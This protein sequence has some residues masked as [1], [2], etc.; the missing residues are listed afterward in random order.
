MN[1]AEMLSY[2]NAL[3]QRMG[4]LIHS[5][6]RCKAFKAA[7][8]AFLNR[9]NQSFL[10]R[11]F[12]IA[13]A[14]SGIAFTSHPSMAQDSSEKLPDHL[15]SFFSSLDARSIPASRSLT[16]ISWWGDSAV[17]GDGYTGQLRK[18]L[19]ERFGDGGAGIV[20]PDP[21]FKGY[22]H[23]QVR[24][25][26]NNWSTESA[27]HRNL[28]H[29]RYGLAGIA[30]QSYGGASSTFLARNDGYDRVTVFFRGAPKRG[31]LQVYAD[32]EGLPRTEHLTHRDTVDDTTWTYTLSKPSTWIRVRAA[33]KG[34][35]EL[36]A[37]ALERSTGGVVLDTMGQVGLR[38]R[39]LLRIDEAH[40]ANQVAL[41]SPNLVAVHFGGNERVDARLTKEKHQGEIESLL[42]R[43]KRGA[44][45]ASCV[46]VG[47]L[48]HGK[49]SRGKVI[50]DPRLT[51]IA[52]AQK[53]A[54]NSKGCAYYDSIAHF[55]GA[56]G[57]QAMV[58]DRLL[59]KD[60]AH[61]TTRGH[62]KMGNL[63][64]DWLFKQY[65]ASKTAPSL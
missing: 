46:V 60:M 25:R 61:L 33:G 17:A 57:L 30:L 15:T 45:G 59:A 16:K 47:P 44:P 34:S 5:P 62:Q 55:G 40:F 52:N 4:S 19:Q 58:K 48:P 51:I 42:T 28:K 3:D 1:L 18:R 32:E 23:K 24:L 49:R 39:G 31:L 43:L 13:L 35:V 41:R 37:V 20:L 63:I 65:D 7:T 64:A 14:V 8:G 10:K 26:R 12:T 36:Y 56:E 29:R 54:A 6:P 21:T 53:D 38:A 11:C 2:R 9:L 27:L 50:L 22:L